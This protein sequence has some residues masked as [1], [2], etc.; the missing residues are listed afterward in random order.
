MEKPT[1]YFAPFA[2]G[3]RP[4]ALFITCS[5]SRVHPRELTGSAPGEVFILRSAGNLVPPPG[6]GLSGEA[7]TIEYAVSALEV[8]EV[9]L[10]G[11]TRCGA[12]QGILQ[13]ELLAD[14]PM[15]AAWLGLAEATRRVVREL[16]PDLQ[17]Q[18]LLDAATQ[19]NVQVQL[20]SLRTI[21]AVA[22]R[23]AAGRL[24][25]HGWVYDVECGEVLAYDAGQGRFVRLDPV[26]AIR[27]PA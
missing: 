8:K 24:K 7:A 18:A 10:C 5:D 26:R 3:Q 6:T 21:P 27:E 11:H 25:L 22:A 15:V 20:Q 9:I 16:H 17:G 14:M 13:P 2:K 19:I 12:M 23:L 4:E 1:S